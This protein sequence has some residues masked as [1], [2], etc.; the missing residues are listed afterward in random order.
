MPDTQSIQTA[1]LQP[2]P[3]IEAATARWL[4]DEADFALGAECANPM[5]QIERWGQDGSAPGVEFT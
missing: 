1:S 3:G 2:P 4:T 5:L